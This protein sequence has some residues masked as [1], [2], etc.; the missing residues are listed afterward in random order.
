[1]SANIKSWSR[2]L[3]ANGYAD[4]IH[5]WHWNEGWLMRRHVHILSSDGSILEITCA[6]EYIRIVGSNIA[7]TP[8]RPYATY[9]LQ[10]QE[11]PTR[12]KTDFIRYEKPAVYMSADEVISLIIQKLQT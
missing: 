6:N 7:P 9:W 11:C 10:S 2:I 5:S 1:M 8:E 4:T 12:P 3:K